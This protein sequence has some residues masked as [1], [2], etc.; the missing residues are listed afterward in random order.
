MKLLAKVSASGVEVVFAILW[1]NLQWRK[2]CDTEITAGADATAQ[3]E[4]ADTGCSPAVEDTF[5]KL[6]RSFG[7]MQGF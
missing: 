2:Q 7:D 1:V 5:T 4:V 3:S 6:G